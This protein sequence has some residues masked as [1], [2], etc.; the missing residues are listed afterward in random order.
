MFWYFLRALFSTYQLIFFRR[1]Q[2][3]NLKHL[4]VKQPVLIALNHPNAFMDA[5]ALSITLYY[6]RTY[7]M[8]RGDAFKP[9]LITTILTWTGIVPIFRMR[10]AGIEGLRKN[11]ASFS[12]VYKLW[13]KNKK[14]I[15]FPEGLCIQERRL[16]SIQKGTARMAFGFMDAYK[17]DDFLIVP[18]G[19]TYSHPA[20]FRTDVYYEAGEAIAV[21]DYYAAYKENQVTG[22]NLLTK[23]LEERMKLLV[24]SLKHTE[25]DL[26]LEQLQPVYKH[27]FLEDNKLDTSRLENHQRFWVHTI[28]RLNSITEKNDGT[29]ERLRTATEEYTKAL[30]KQNVAD[31]NISGN[32]NSV[33]A[34]FWLIIGFPF[35][36]IGKLLSFLP[37][38]AAKSIAHKTAKNIEFRTSV[39]YVTGTFFSLFYLIIELLVIWFIWKTWW[40]L[41]AYVGVK[42]LTG[43]IALA[44]SYRKKRWMGELKTAGLRRNNPDLLNKLKGQRTEILSILTGK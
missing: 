3:K 16:R 8:A 4:R 10:D 22:I 27:T 44:Y 23:V 12:I 14:I 26:L 25:N 31:E 11:D 28:D 42:V 6:P 37:W 21:K 5:I 20:E 13:T 1:F 7:Y 38:S 24:P 33:S 9:G 17:R 35:Y 39:N 19:V 18:V 41:L 36:F 43:L 30:A 32:G 29:I 2:G 15:V 40:L 34:L